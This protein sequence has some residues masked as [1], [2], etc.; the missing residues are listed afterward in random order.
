MIN[1]A[2]KYQKIV[3]NTVKTLILSLNFVVISFFVSLLM[4]ISTASPKNK[5]PRNYLKN[6]DFQQSLKKFLYILTRI[7]QIFIS[8]M[9]SSNKCRYHI[10]CSQYFLLAIKKYNIFIAIIKTISRIVSC[11]PYSKRDYFDHP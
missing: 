9:I 2:L 7:Y 3:K 6:F 4:S 10:S 1:S 5:M 8:S 11:N